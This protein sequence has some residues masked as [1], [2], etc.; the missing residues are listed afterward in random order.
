M[1]N[2]QHTRLQTLL[3]NFTYTCGATLQELVVL[4]E[5]QNV[6][7]FVWRSCRKAVLLS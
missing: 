5:F 6:E 4:Q 2:D 7:S 3:E 1:K